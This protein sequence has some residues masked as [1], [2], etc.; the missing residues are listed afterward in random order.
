M[1]EPAK[2]RSKKLLPWS[3]NTSYQKIEENEDIEIM[4]YRF[5]KIVSKLKSLGMIYPHSLQVQKLVRSLPK[6]WET[7]AAIMDDRDLHNMTY[8]EL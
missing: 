8:D 5:S 2:S 7:K 4:F 3:I 1:K 6:T